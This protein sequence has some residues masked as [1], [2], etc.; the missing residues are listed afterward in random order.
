MKSNENSFNDIVKDKLKSIITQYGFK[1]DDQKTIAQ[2]DYHSEIYFENSYLEIQATRWS[3]TDDYFLLFQPIIKEEETPRLNIDTILNATMRDNDYYKINVYEKALNSAHKTDFQ[4][5]FDLCERELLR[6]CKQIF[7]GDLSCWTDFVKY[8]IEV[9]V[10]EYL[11]LSSMSNKEQ[12]EQHIQNQLRQL[13][14]YVKG[15]EPLYSLRDVV[16]RL[17]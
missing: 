3:Q 9:N 10:K 14:Q 17:A 5:Y 16:K 8:H 15:H 12:L 1:I 11:R 6:N 2:G 4:L 7:E 13:E